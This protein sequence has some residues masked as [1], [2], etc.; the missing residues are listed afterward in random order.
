MSII[1]VL[2]FVVGMIM[3][4]KWFS[5]ENTVM[6]INTSVSKVT[7][8]LAGAISLLNTIRGAETTDLNDCQKEQIIKIGITWHEIMVLII[9]EVIML[10]VIVLIVRLVKQ[11]YRL[12]NINNLEMPDSYVKQNCCPIR[13]LGSKSDIYLEISSITNVSSIKIYIGTT[14]GYPTQFSIS[15]K[16]TKSDMQYHTSIFYD[17]INFDWSKI[18][19]KY[20]DELIFFLSTIQVPLYGK[21]KTRKLLTCL[22]SQYR[23]VIQC[24]NIVYVLNGHEIV[25]SKLRVLKELTDRNEYNINDS[26]IDIVEELI[27]V[28]TD[29]IMLNEGACKS[30]QP[31][32]ILENSQNQNEN[33]TQIEVQIEPSPHSLRKI[34]CTYCK[35][36]IY[37]SK[38]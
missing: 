9:Y 3:V 5:I 34:Q 6:T 31:D 33:V 16:L 17:E 26:H 10:I 29:A 14:M 4:M 28:E 18:E 13:M 21:F 12:C 20:Q 27:H 7:K 1:G 8:Q 23:I 37:M 11:A 30:G 19:F 32:H 15:G 35:N 2:S 22:D 25:Q 36:Y 24:Q 38:L